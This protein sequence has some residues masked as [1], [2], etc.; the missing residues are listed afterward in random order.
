[1]QYAYFNLENQKVIPSPAIIFFLHQSLIVVGWSIVWIRCIF[2]FDLFIYVFI[3]CDFGA[4][5]EHRSLFSR[6]YLIHTLNSIILSRYSKFSWKNVKMAI[7]RRV[8]TPIDEPSHV[9]WGLNSL[10]FFTVTVNN[11]IE[12]IIFLYHI[13][14]ILLLIIRENLLK[15]LFTDYQI[16]EIM[17]NN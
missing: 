6:L 1:M 16:Y 13:N 11:F 3:S 8:A 2:Y 4:G 9:D 7:N 5:L 10:L 12:D 17:G 15:V 14:V